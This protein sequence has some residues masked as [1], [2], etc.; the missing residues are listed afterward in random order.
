MKQQNLDTEEQIRQTELHR[1]KAL[2]A[3]DMA[4]ARAMIADDFQLIPPPGLVLSKEE[5]L[6]A[7]E[8]GALRYYVWETVSPIAV[9]LYGNGAVI[10]Y[11]AHIEVE[12]GG[13]KMAGH[14]W[15]TD[16]YE[17]R[18]GRWQ[19]VWSQGTTAGAAERS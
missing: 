17:E 18:D 3:R 9:R 10:R 14:Y 6:G 1:M 7:I 11:R 5:Y 16:L 2:V 12:S 8:A 4:A 19:I 15:F 13:T